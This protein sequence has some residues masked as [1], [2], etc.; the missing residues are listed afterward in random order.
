MRANAGNRYS[1]FYPVEYKD[2]YDDQPF[3]PLYVECTDGQTEG[4]TEPTFDKNLALE[5]LYLL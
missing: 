1:K 4:C 3:G 5:S 2:E